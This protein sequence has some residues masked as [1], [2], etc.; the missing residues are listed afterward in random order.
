MQFTL[1]GCVRTLPSSGVQPTTPFL[2]FLL[3][4]QIQFLYK[5]ISILRAQYVNILLYMTLIKC[6]IVIRI[7]H[8]NANYQ[9]V[10]NGSRVET[11]LYLI[12]AMLGYNPAQT[13][14]FI[15]AMLFEFLLAFL[16]PG[17]SLSRNFISCKYCAN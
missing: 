14:A 1:D 6:V 11:I 13:I 16:S 15:N 7:I 9:I 2:V 17:L 10:L 4:I 8:S 5:N 12:T 3:K